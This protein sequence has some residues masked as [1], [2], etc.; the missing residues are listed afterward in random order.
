MKALLALVLAGLLLPVPALAHRLKVFAAV[1][2]GAIEGYGFFIGGGRPMAA[3]VEIA[4]ATGAVQ[5]HGTTDGEGRFRW[6]VPAPADYTV[7]VNAQDGHIARVS[8]PAARF[9]GTGEASLAAAIPTSGQPGPP[10]GTVA[11]PHDP[12]LAPLIE[13]AVQHQIEPLLE[14]IE[15]M[16]SRLR[17][18]D[19]MSGVFLIL[20]AAGGLSAFMARRKGPGGSP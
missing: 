16:D 19:I 18:T 15:E 3:L 1:E 4:D 13:A 17:L 20:G 11:T 2:D 7:T 8:L 5:F 10:P 14:R 9:G 12:N 6:V